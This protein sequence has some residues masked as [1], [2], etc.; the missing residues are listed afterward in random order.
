MTTIKAAIGEASTRAL[1]AADPLAGWRDRFILPVGSDGRPK[2]YL[3]GMSLGAQPVGSREA[4]QRELDA[5]ARLGVEAWFGDDGWLEA[6]GA[7][8]DVTARIVGARPTE[9]A[10]LNTL[11]VN[12]HLLMAAFFRPAGRRTAILIDAPT[13]P[14]DRYAVVSQLRHHGLDPAVDLVVIGPRTGEST[15]RVEDIEGA[16]HQHRGRLA[17]VLLAGVNYANG[18]LHDIERLTSA[19][20]ETG[21]VAGWDLAHAVGNVP[22]ALHDADVDFAAWCTYKYLNGGPGALAQLFVNERH[23]DALPARR[24]A[25]W[26]GNAEATRFEMADTIDPAPGAAG[27]RISTPPILS[28]APIAV[29]LAMFDE[30]GMSALRERSVALTAYLEMAVESLVPD[31]EIVTPRDPTARGSQLSIRLPDAAARQAALEA[32]DVV[33]DFREPDI[34]RMA[35]VPLYVSYHDAWRAARALAATAPSPTT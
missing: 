33:A 10:T 1:D 25:G 20:H 29:S 2:A 26:W 6:D 31:S 11:T 3:A 14:S 21:A 5:W 30:V 19:V 27:W 18:Q 7:I 15:T 24:L 35:P 16:I 9:V 22:L 28:L 4:V 13:F 32:L 8:R 17:L 23:A 34:V 12:L